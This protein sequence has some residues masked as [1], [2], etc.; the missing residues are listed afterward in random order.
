MSGK[1]HEGVRVPTRIAHDLFNEKS[2][3]RLRRVASGAHHTLAL[4]Q[5]GKIYAWGDPESGKLGRVLNTRNKDQQALMIEK[6]GARDAVN[7]FAGNH[8]SFYVNKR[9]A[10]YSW[11]L[12]NHGQLGLGHKEN[13]SQPSLVLP[14]LQGQEVVMLAGGE[15][16]SIAVTAEGKVFCFGR[17]DEGQCGR[18]DL[19]GQYK[20]RKAQEEYEKLMKQME[21]EE[22]RKKEEA[23]AA[24]KRAAE[25]DNAAG[26]QE[27][28][29]KGEEPLIINTEVKPDVAAE[30][31][32]Q[33]VPAT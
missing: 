22:A 13:T 27:E 24:A 16:H 30:G 18:G 21:E 1:F 8:H 33:A 4:T 23:E 7:I 20:R 11:G 10:L 5:G 19:Y 15:H 31:E 25:G 32:S 28:E 14:P 9:G 12:N 26:E 29:K 2:K 3:E 6:V 17:N